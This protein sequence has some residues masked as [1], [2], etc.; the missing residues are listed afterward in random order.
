VPLEDHSR[1]GKVLN[2]KI[3]D[4]SQNPF[5]LSFNDTTVYLVND[6]GDEFSGPILDLLDSFLRSQDQTIYVVS[7]QAKN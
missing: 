3:C 2:L 7:K 5:F 1:S 4:A 6:I